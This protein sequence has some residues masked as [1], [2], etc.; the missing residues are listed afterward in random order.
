MTT[1]AAMQEASKDPVNLILAA[2]GAVVLACV[3]PR[4]LCGKP[5]PHPPAS[6]CSA[7]PKGQAAQGAVATAAPAAAPQAG[8]AEAALP[9]RH[10]EARSA[11]AAVAPTAAR[12]A[13][14]A[15][16]A[17]AAS[18]AAGKAA[19]RPYIG[20]RVEKTL[21]VTDRAPPVE[22][23]RQVI[24]TDVVRRVNGVEVQS[25]DAYFE[26]ESRLAVGDSVELVL[27]RQKKEVT[28]TLTVLDGAEY[29]Y[30]GRVDHVGGSPHR[31]GTGSGVSP[32]A[33]D[34]RRASISPKPR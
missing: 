24:V 1:L 22:R 18:E 15:P 11:P 21:T 13:Q 5:P 33:R 12:P 29:G 32:T 16:A 19:G 31:S 30:K 23:A 20:I 10:P 3:I 14:P 8:G 25:T 2:G 9:P 26:A 7:S 6:C 27:R 34:Q 28:A 4:L 17:P